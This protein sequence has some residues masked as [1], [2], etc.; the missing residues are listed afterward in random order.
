MNIKPKGLRITIKPW[1]EEV[2]EDVYVPEEVKKMPVGIIVA[3]GEEVTK[4]DVGEKVIFS[5]HYYDEITEDLLIVLE[6]DIWGIVE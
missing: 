5:P 3:V 6:K 4:Y 1:K 2:E